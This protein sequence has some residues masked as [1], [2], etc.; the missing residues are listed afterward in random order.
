MNKPDESPQIVLNRLIE[1]CKDGEHAFRNAARKAHDEGLRRLC[2]GWAGQRA[3]FAAQLRAALRRLGATPLG[4]GTIVGTLQR[5]LENLQAAFLGVT[6]AELIA[7]LERDEE[8]LLN[9]YDSVDL[10]QLP[11]AVRTLVESQRKWLRDTHAEVAALA[12]DMP[13]VR[14]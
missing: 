14:A 8:A 1:A 5:G 12:Q 11:P 13:V 7:R 10:D 3:R 6:D 9:A 2:D 4:R